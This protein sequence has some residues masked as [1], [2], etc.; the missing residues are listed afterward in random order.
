VTRHRDDGASA[1]FHYAPAPRFI[2]QRAAAE[3]RRYAAGEIMRTLFT[4][5]LCS[6]SAQ[7]MADRAAYNGVRD[8]RVEAGGT[9]AEHHHDWRSREAFVRLTDSDSGTELL[10]SGSPPL[11]L[12]WL[13][14]DGGFLVGFSEIRIANPTQLF[15]VSRDGS[16]TYRER[17]TCDDHRLAQANCSESVTNFVYWY[18]SADPSVELSVTEGKAVAISFNAPPPYDCPETAAEKCRSPRVTLPLNK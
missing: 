10:R 8:I 6:L 17:I 1:P 14:P 16:Q 4:I 18:N 5:I 15:V 11:T 3:L 7:A 9:V 12:L 13:S 2:R